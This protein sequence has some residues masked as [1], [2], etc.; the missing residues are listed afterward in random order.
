MTRGFESLTFRKHRQDAYS[1]QQR[2]VYL[3]TQKRH[4]EPYEGHQGREAAKMPN[5]SA[6]N[7]TPDER[8]CTARCSRAGK[9]GAV[10]HEGRVKAQG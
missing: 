10:M 7:T 3:E 2:H 1:T 6:N 9:P 4:G 5:G 8:Q